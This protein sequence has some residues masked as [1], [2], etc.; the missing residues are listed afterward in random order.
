MSEII[1]AHNVQNDLISNVSF[2]VNVLLILLHSL[3]SSI[4][5]AA[6]ILI[7]TF[8]YSLAH[9]LAHSIKHACPHSQV[10]AFRHFVFRFL[11]SKLPTLS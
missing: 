2:S 8:S 7:H 5:C 9:S 4:I 3:L 1:T 10:E 6:Y 11:M